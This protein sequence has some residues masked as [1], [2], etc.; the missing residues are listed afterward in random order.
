[1][2]VLHFNHRLVL[3][4]RCLVFMYVYCICGQLLYECA[5]RCC[6]LSAHYL[7]SI[8]DLDSHLRRATSKL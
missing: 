3:L 7:L 6:E 5:G 1:M 8:H 4:L 2:D